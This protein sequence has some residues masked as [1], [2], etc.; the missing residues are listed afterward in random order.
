[1]NMPHTIDISIGFIGVD[2]PFSTL[3]SSANKSGICLQQIL[4][5]TDSAHEYE[6]RKH[7]HTLRIHI[8]PILIPFDENVVLFCLFQKAFI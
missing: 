1:M 5:H 4:N 6:S 3:H 7:T 8:T 2:Y